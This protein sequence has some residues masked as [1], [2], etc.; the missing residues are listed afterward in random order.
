[1][2]NIW[3]ILNSTLNE[4]VNSIIVITTVRTSMI[5]IFVITTPCGLQFRYLRM[6]F[7]HRLS[8]GLFSS[9]MQS[10]SQWRSSM[11]PVSN[12][13]SAEQMRKQT[14]VIAGGFATLPTSLLH[15]GRRWCRKISL[16]PHAREKRFEGFLLTWSKWMN[17]YCHIAHRGLQ[18]S[19]KMQEEK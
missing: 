2:R 3:F 13:S 1:M 10:N 9:R 19:Y 7:T 11:F 17:E 15:A 18:P 14:V 12:F 8:I 4:P 5:N 16:T 6:K